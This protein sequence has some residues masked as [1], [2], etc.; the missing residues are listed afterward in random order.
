MIPSCASL[1]EQ[2]DGGNRQASYMRVGI[3][4]RKLTLQQRRHLAQH[5]QSKKVSNGTIIRITRLRT[6]GHLSRA[7]IPRPI[8]PVEENNCVVTPV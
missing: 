8:F 5:T 7:N 1:C 6:S 4:P 3:S 2:I